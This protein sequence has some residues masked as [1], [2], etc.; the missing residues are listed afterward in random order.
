MVLE[1]CRGAVAVL[2]PFISERE[3]AASSPS[4]APVARLFAVR[5][6]APPHLDLLLA[7][8]LD[9]AQHNIVLVIALKHFPLRVQNDP[10]CVISKLCGADIDPLTVYVPLVMVRAVRT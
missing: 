10:E 1:A 9:V 2:P 6:I 5:N 7:H 4:R 8:I 3:F